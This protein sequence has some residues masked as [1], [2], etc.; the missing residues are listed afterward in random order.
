MEKTIAS[1]NE[2]IK[3]LV[4]EMMCE[5]NDD[6]YDSSF[7]FTDQ[8][9][10]DELHISLRFPGV[11]VKTLNNDVFTK[12]NRNLKADSVKLVLPDDTLPCKSILNVEHQSYALT[13]DKIHSLYDYKIHLISRYNIPAICVVVTNIGEGDETLILDSHGDAFK[14]YLRVITDEDINQRLNNLI[15]KVNNNQDLSVVDALDFI[16]ILLFSRKKV[17]K[18]HTCEVVDLFQKVAS[19]LDMN[20]QLNLHFVLKKLIRAHYADNLI[21]TRELLTVITKAIHSDLLDELPTLKKLRADNEL[22]ELELSLKDELISQ[23][24]ELIYQRDAEI[25]Q[26]NA[27][28]LR[29]KQKL[30]L[31]NI[32]DD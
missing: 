6:P 17:A 12:N 23:K 22:K 32:E 30:I 9:Y 19:K 3:K 24:D 25:S 26:K 2:K 28:I 10:P 29:L 14:V 20:L 13:R 31:N 16:N 5:N 18:Q 1:S 15:S 4:D 21:K 11:F 27:E 8:F 7:R